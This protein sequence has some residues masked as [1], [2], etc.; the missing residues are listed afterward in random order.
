MATE[1]VVIVTRIMIVITLIRIL[2]VIITVTILVVLLKAEDLSER[3]NTADLG[4]LLDHFQ[5]LRQ[6]SCPFVTPSTV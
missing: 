6:D 5:L 3:T 1:I 2:V 4:P